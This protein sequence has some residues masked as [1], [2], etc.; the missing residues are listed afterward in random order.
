MNSSKL[1][2]F[3]QTITTYNPLYI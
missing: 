2:I 3:V 1:I